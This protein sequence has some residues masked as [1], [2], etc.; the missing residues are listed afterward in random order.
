MT[1]VCL[2][3]ARSTGFETANESWVT[4][5][6]VVPADPVDPEAPL[7]LDELLPLLHAA[8][9]SAPA[10]IGATMRSRTSGSSG[11]EVDEVGVGVGL[12]REQDAVVDARRS[13]SSASSRC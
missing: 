5:V 6:T 2:V 10:M 7:E 9:A 3:N 13:R 8:S 1:P 11:V 12:D 4:S